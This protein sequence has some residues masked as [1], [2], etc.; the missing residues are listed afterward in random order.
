[1]RHLLLVANGIKRCVQHVDNIYYININ[2]IM[3]RQSDEY[4]LK[5]GTCEVEETDQGQNHPQMSYCVLNS[6]I[7]SPGP[8]C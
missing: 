8:Y 5:V 6:I 2:I 1:M 3:S 7:Q 4:F